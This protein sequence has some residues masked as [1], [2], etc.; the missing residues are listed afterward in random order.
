MFPGNLIRRIKMCIYWHVRS[1]MEMMVRPGHI[2][3]LD[4]RLGR[5]QS[6]DTQESI[7]FEL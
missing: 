5:G 2:A 1:G 3:C 6:I 4:G 7:N